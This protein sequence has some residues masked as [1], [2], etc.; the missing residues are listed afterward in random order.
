MEEEDKMPVLSRAIKENWAEDDRP[1]EK[2]MR[3]GFTGLSVA[4]LLAIIVG[5]GSRGEN[6]VDLCQ[7][8]LRDHDNKLYVLA[9]RTWRDLMRYHGVGEV[10]A[11]EIAAAL[12]L[13]RRYQTEK[14]DLNT[15]ILCSQDAYECLQPLMRDLYHEEIWILTVNRQKRVTHRLRVS[16]GGTAATVGDVKVILKLALENLAEG[17]ILSHNHPSDSTNPSRQDDNLTRRVKQGC[18]AIGIELVDHIIVCRGGLY[19]SYND[20]GRL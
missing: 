18:D 10:K 5:S 13:A 14:F 6:V 20:H 12:E 4:E 11:V 2:A 15:Q 7:R 9:R 1:R 16:S 8:I 19:Y 3:Y 17:I